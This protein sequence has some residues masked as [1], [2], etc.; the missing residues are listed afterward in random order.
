MYK[1]INS[2]F[3]SSSVYLLASKIISLKYFNWSK[4]SMGSGVV[5]FE[6]FVIK[7]H[8]TISK[9]FNHIESE[10]IEFNK[11]DFN[12]SRCENNISVFKKELN[13]NEIEYIEKKLKTFLYPL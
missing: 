7:K 3:N 9:I 6:D 12:F 2:A 4:L 8:D 13:K 1:N 5:N 11:V 10:Q